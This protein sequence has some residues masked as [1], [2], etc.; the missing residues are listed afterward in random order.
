MH[1]AHDAIHLSAIGTAL[2]ELSLPIED[3]RK[4]PSGQDFVPL[5]LTDGFVS[6]RKTHRGAVELVTTS[7]KRTL[8]AG[9]IAPAS[10]DAVLLCAENFE[11]F[12]EPDA[13]PGS[14]A[15]QARL[16]IA[17]ALAGMGLSVSYLMGLWSAGCAN[18]VAAMALAKGLVAQNC[19]KNV[20][21]I[22][23]DCDRQLSARIMNN[24]GAVYSD[25]AASCIVSRAVHGEEGYRIDGIALTADVSLAAIDPRKNP[26]GYLVSL[27]RAIS[28]VKQ[29][30]AQQLGRGLD[31]YERIL[32]PNLRRRSLA[33]L[34]ESFRLPLTR[35]DMPLKSR[36]AHVNA[37]DHLL[38]LELDL[39][40]PPTKDG[41]LLFNPGPFAWN[42]MGLTRVPAQ[43]SPRVLPQ[44]VPE[45]VNDPLPLAA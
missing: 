5:F 37:A 34:A 10:I 35:F 25:G 41:V 3:L 45:S 15:L 39:L 38:A 1:H 26:F 31:S 22:T 30:I 32:T 12:V 2:G 36:V 16:R 4:E 20:L 6:Y 23:V 24:G 27:N 11:E 43:Q 42:F 7:V 14:V 29:G 8:E 9:G 28:R 40:E 17:A 18:F 13:A 21:V 19:A 33:I 44:P